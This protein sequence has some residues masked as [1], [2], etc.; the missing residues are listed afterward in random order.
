[1]KV[2]IDTNI[3]VDAIYSKINNCIKILD[4]ADK[5]YITPVTSLELEKEYNLVAGKVLLNAMKDQFL[6]GSLTA[7]HFDVAQEELYRY[8]NQINRIL[9]NKAEKYA[10]ESNRS[11]SPDKDDNKII[12]LA[13]DSNSRAIITKNV[14]HFR[15]VEEKSIKNLN[16]ELIMIMTPKQFTRYF[17]EH[18]KEFLKDSSRINTI[19]LYQGDFKA[20]KHWTYE[21]TKVISDVNNHFG[22]V[23]S[24]VEIRNKYKEYTE[25]L[26]SLNMELLRIEDKSKS[27]K[28]IETWVNDY[29]KNLKQL[30]E[31]E[32]SFMNKVFRKEEIASVKKD[33]SIIKDMLNRY[34]V[35]DRSDYERLL[36]L[37]NKELE[38]KAVLE[39]DIDVCKS[40][41]AL[42]SNAMDAINK[43]LLKDASLEKGIDLSIT[44][45]R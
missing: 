42:L 25:K 28:E 34:D 13:I 23:L 8:H 1:M 31:L 36:S 11:I 22:K 5:G 33:I 21:D 43:A 45:D 17:K 10:I 32:K 44:L 20:A 41:I 35:K 12:N 7:S 24:I 30:G 4:Y 27:L 9:I 19:S 38:K 16:G 40:S 14:A 26:S 3:I 18:K 39:N 15:C 6:S 29:E 37:H 2:I